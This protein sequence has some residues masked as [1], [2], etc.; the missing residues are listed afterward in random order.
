M[1]E[2]SHSYRYRAG[3]CAFEQLVFLNLLELVEELIEGCIALRIGSF[4]NEARNCLIMRTARL[5]VSV[6]QFPDLLP[7]DPR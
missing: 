2:P 1:C 4:G 3:I 7:I 6:R 5:A